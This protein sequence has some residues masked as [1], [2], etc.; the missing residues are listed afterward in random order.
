MSSA[1]NKLDVLPYAVVADEDL[2]NLIYEALREIDF[3]KVELIRLIT[4]NV[5]LSLHSIYVAPRHHEVEAAF[6]VTPACLGS[7]PQRE[8]QAGVPETS[9]CLGV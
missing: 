3:P 5:F 4:S 8:S 7:W 9:A 6:F 1:R 2:P